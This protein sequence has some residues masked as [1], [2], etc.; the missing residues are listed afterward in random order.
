M[1]NTENEKTAKVSSGFYRAPRAIFTEAKYKSLSNDAKLLY[2]L[3]SDRASMSEKNGWIDDEGRVYIYFT[4]PKIS[5]AIGC[6]RDKAVRLLKE[7]DCE[8]GAG[9]IQRKHRGGPRPDVIYVMPLEEAIGEEEFAQKNITGE[10]QIFLPQKA[11]AKDDVLQSQSQTSCSRKTEPQAVVLSDPNYINNNYNNINYNKSNHIS[12]RSERKG[13]DETDWIEERKKYKEIIEYNIDYDIFK[14]EYENKWFALIAD[15]M[16]SVVCSK[17]SSVR[18]GGE[19]Y[20]HEVVKKRFL[21]LNSEH[22][23]YVYDAMKHVTTPIHNIRAYLITSLFRAP[24]TMDS[25]YAARVRSD[26]AS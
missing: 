25:W 18:I 1:N 16:L 21:E 9:L 6:G 7:L 8:T 3:M 17:E 23:K 19:L 24:E 20:P 22:V 11:V 13:F 12:Q 14:E 5:E 2:M 15:I 4:L 10:A 26:M